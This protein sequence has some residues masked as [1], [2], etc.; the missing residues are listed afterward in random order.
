MCSSAPEKFLKQKPF[1]LGSNLRAWREHVGLTQAEVERRAGLAHNAL[2]RIETEAV[3]PKLETIERIAS[4]LDLG[5]EQIHYR[6][7]PS[8]HI[9]E[10]TPVEESDIKRLLTMI[11]AL[12]PDR[13]RR[14]TR[15]LITVIEEVQR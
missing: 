12:P 6:S 9:R 1:S 15:L 7:P 3:S 2:S 10:S 11:E 5:F 14:M 8:M 13:R 4:A